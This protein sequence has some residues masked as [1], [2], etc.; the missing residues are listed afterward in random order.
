[1]ALRFL[2]GVGGL[3]QGGR[4]A[5]GTDRDHGRWPQAVPEEG[6]HAGDVAGRPVDNGGGV[7]F[8]QVGGCGCK[9]EEFP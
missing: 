9:F 2:S 3:P 4:R 7:V 6:R 5:G 8:G 1:L